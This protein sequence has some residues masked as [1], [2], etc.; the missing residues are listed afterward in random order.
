[1]AAVDSIQQVI[2]EKPESHAELQCSL[3]K[4]TEVLELVPPTTN[5]EHAYALDRQVFYTLFRLTYRENIDPIQFEAI[6]QQACVHELENLS[7]EMV[8]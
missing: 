8:V 6:W 1:M 4:L 2:L 7:T 5:L 3:A